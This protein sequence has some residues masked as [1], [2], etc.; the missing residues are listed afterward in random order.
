MLIADKQGFYCAISFYIRKFFLQI[1][2]TKTHSVLLECEDQDPEFELL[3]NTVQILFVWR[4]LPPFGA[5]QLA[6][7]EGSTRYTD[8]EGQGRTLFAKLSWVF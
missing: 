6:Y 2:N 7:Q 3:R 4:F 5:L 1:N 8:E